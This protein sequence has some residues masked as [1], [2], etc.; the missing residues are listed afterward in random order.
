MQ[1][2]YDRIYNFV[3]RYITLYNIL[4]HVHVNNIIIILLLSYVMYLYLNMYVY[5]PYI[6]LP[7]LLPVLSVL[8]YIKQGCNLQLTHRNLKT[9]W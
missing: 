2:Y 9:F 3:G 4:Q 6:T 8:R 1:Y 5:E 7:V